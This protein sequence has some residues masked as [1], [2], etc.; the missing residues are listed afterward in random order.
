MF[1]W[2]VP[3]PG[4]RDPRRF[5]PRLYAYAIP[6]VWIIKP[7]LQERGTDVIVARDTRRIPRGSVDPT[8]KNFH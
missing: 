8:V 4:E 6:Y 3:E 7:E 2:G 5:K 1:T